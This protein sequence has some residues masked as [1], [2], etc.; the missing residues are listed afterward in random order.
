VN[1]EVLAEWMLSVA[2][3]HW[4]ASGCVP[5]SIASPSRTSRHAP[6]ILYKDDLKIHLNWTKN[7]RQKVRKLFNTVVIQLV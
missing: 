6:A 4:L 2:Q 7:M 1:S 5:R 3:G